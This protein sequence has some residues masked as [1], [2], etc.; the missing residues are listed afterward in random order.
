MLKLGDTLITRKHHE[1]EESGCNSFGLIED[2]ELEV[3]YIDEYLLTTNDGDFTVEPDNG[4]HS[5]KN[6]YKLK[7]TK[8]D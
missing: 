7:A 1:I 2:R 3:L 5:W 8:E 4:G 6:F